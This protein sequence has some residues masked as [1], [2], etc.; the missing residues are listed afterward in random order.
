MRK[1]FRFRKYGNGHFE[2]HIIE[3]FAGEFIG[4]KDLDNK[5]LYEGDTVKAYDKMLKEVIIGSITYKA[6][7]FCIKTCNGYYQSLENVMNIKLLKP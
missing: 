3:D 6:P 2:N 4:I 5:M 1:H 7:T